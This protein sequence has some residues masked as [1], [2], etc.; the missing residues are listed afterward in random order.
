MSL[1]KAAERKPLQKVAQTAEQLSVSR[2]KVY[3]L[4]DA[5]ELEFVKLGKS[6]RIPQEAIDRLIVESTVGGR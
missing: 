4:M 2:S 5:G 1:A 3:S 6:R